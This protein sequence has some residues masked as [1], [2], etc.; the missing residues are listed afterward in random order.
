M[1]VELQPQTIDLLDRASTVLKASTYDE[2][3]VKAVSEILEQARQSSSDGKGRTVEDIIEG[4]RSLRG[5]LSGVTIEEIVAM[6]HE[7]LA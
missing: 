5:M 4:F 3:I 7:G 1:N 2:V 6:K